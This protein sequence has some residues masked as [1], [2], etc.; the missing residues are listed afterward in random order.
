M[1]AARKFVNCGNNVVVTPARLVELTKGQVDYVLGRNPNS[2]SYMV[3]Y[4][5]RFPQKIPHHGS[6]IPLI[7]QHP[8]HMQCHEGDVFQN[9]G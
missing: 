2:M 1:K 3:G 9:S 5:T 7:D 6:V 4:G 8:K